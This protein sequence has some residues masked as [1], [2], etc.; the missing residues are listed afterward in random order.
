[1]TKDEIYEY[2]A[3]VYLGKKEKH[4]KRKRRHSISNLFLG[5]IALAVV[6]LVSAFYSFSAFLSARPP[7]LSVNSVIFA[8]N[9]SP[10]RVKYNLNDPYPQIKKFSLPLPKVNAGKYQF[11][12]FSIRA[13]EGNPGIVKIVLTNKKRETASYF[14]DQVDF[15]WQRHDIPLDELTTI[16]DWSNLTDVSFVFEAWNVEKKKGTVLIEDICFSSE[17]QTYRTK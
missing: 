9:N 16:S 8:L 17:A 14:L 11:L 2:L 3:S 15:H 12:S 13:E 4:K 1:M 5:K 6:I 7:Q 10:I